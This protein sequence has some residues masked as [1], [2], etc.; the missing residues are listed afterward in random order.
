MKLYFD[1]GPLFTTPEHTWP[2]GVPPS[3]VAVEELRPAR[4][5]SGS[6]GLRLASLTRV[7]QAAQGSRATSHTSQWAEYPSVIDLVERGGVDLPSLACGLDRGHLYPA[8]RSGSTAHRLSAR[9]VTPLSGP[10]CVLPMLAQ[11]PRRRGHPR[12]LGASPGSPRRSGNAS[13][14]QATPSFSSSSA[15]SSVHGGRRRPRLIA[16]LAQKPR[17]HD[18]RRA[19]LRR[20]HF[21]SSL[22]DAV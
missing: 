11:L 1:A 9:A 13:L 10:R 3:A 5:Y 15:T 17:S 19:S 22:S 2:K 6:T 20:V 18:V 8:E 16:S 14:I 4:G 7:R 12:R 21:A